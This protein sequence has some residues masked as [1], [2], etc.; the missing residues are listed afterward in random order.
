MKRSRPVIPEQP[1][2]RNASNLHQVKR[3]EDLEALIRENEIED[4][5]A[6]LAM[7]QG[8]RLLWR[9][10]TEECGLFRQTFREGHADTS[11][12]YEGKRSVALFVQAEVG[13]ADATAMELMRSERA[14]GDTTEQA[15]R[16]QLAEGGD[17]VNG[18]D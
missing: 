13:Q 3:A 5:R 8:R 14:R 2:V 18:D 10:M 7:P 15:I 6:V 9:L 4:F 12:F 11:A 16:A 17:G 1:L